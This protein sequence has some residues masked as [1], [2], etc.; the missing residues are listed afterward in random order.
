MTAHQA[1][2][3][4]PKWL[5][6]VGIGEDGWEGLSH[7]AQEAILSAQ[8]IYGGSRH[9]ALVPEVKAT[10]LCWPSPMGLALRQILT[11]HRRWRKVAVLAS[12][13]PMLFGVGAS[14]TPHVEPAEFQ[15]Y[16]QV[17]A[18]SLACARLGWPVAEVSLISVV[19]R[20]IEQIYRHL[21][22]GQRLIIYSE[23]GATP[24]KVARLLDECGYG[25]STMSVLQNLGGSKEHRWD[26]RAASW[27]STPCSDLNVIAVLCMPGD[28]AATLSTVPGLPDATFETDGQLTK[29]EVRAVTLARLS[30][31][32]RQILWD[33][34]A[35]SG[36]ISIEW[37]R[38]H[39]S[40]SAIA[41][42]D[43]PERAARIR[44]N[45]MRLGVPGLQVIQGP[46]P[47]T[48]G[49]LT[50][51]D[52]IFIGGGLQDNAMFDACWAR[53]R[54]GGRLVVNAV[55]V[56]SQARL[57][58]LED[59]YGGE[60]VRISIERAAPVGRVLGWRPLMPVTQWAVVKP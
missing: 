4:D 54:S 38:S 14:L 33:V 20:S 7:E 31:L 45:A 58:S 34:G 16:P 11:E 18:L 23:N 41:F 39:V 22:P 44:E 48:F 52:A 47:S 35:G 49:D 27:E 36:S 15:V 56:A 60:L 28:G 13:D 43:E 5:S 51:P 46:A 29:R 19:N 37:M 32:P 3:E 59:T 30:P 1:G 40:C 55:T 6:I 8:I 57:A 21:A 24:E 53:L 25:P 42:E 50:S 2:V 26:F 9:L 10:R 17:S 12:G